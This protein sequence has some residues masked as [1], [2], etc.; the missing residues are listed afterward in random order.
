MATTTL[1]NTLSALTAKALLGQLTWRWP[2]AALFYRLVGFAAFQFLIAGILAVAGN[3]Q[4][5]AASAAWWPITAALTSLAGLFFLIWLFRREGARFFDLYRFERQSWR[6]DAL[7]TLGVLVLSGPVSYLPGPLVGNWLWGDVALAYNLFFS[8]LPLWALII[9]L[10]A[11]PLLIALTELPTYFG[12]IMPR[13]EALT[14]NRWL[15]VLVPVLVLAA[16]HA[17][18]PLIM[19]WRF[20]LWR[21]LMFLP[22]ALLVGGV[23]SWRPR[24]LPYFLIAHGLMDLMTVVMLFTV[25]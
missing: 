9:S 8:P 20:I 21:A 24:L 23:L 19:D 11:F 22:F 18:L 13:L 6:T 7:L 1:S 4:P 10:V 14:G 17:T 3:A 16:Q 2:I 15:A 5:W 12:Y 25:N